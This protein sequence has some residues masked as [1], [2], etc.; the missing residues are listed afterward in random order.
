[1]SF[2]ILKNHFVMFRE[3]I[4]VLTRHR[5]LTWEMAKREITDRYAGQLFGVLWA[6]G[7]PLFLMGIYVF[8][9]GVVFK[10]RI[11]GTRELPLDY[12][13]YLLS[14]LIP[15]M[16][17]Q[18]AMNKSAS[19]ILANANLV[20]QVVFPLEVLPV[21]GVIAAFITQMVSTLILVA[22]VLFKYGELSWT[23]ILI[24]ALFFFQLVAMMGVSFILSAFGAYFRDLK[25][26]VQIFS[27]AGMYIIPMFYLPKMVPELFKPVLYLNPFSH[28]VWCYQ[29]VFYFGQF[30]HPWAWGVFVTLSIGVFYLG[31]LVFKKLKVAFG[32]VL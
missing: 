16:A 20:K 27:I 25:D 29:D 11:G 26:F 4:D 21:K 19:V 15:Y 9:F 12:A 6:I 18:E 22:Y 32:S 10:L 14:G 23:Y 30:K 8:V 5:L 24:P 28:L 13:T 1:M 3:L 31:Y 7:H 17:F 2:L